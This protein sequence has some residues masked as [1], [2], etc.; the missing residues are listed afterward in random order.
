MSLLSRGW[1]SLPCAC[2]DLDIRLLRKEWVAKI[3]ILKNPFPEALNSSLIRFFVYRLVSQERTSVLPNQLF[4][5]EAGE[6]GQ[7]TGN[8]LL[9]F[10]IGAT[11]RTPKEIQCFLYAGY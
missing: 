11:I 2:S 3:A 5:L 8:K 6:R 7:V 1:N 10:C 4:A 9:F